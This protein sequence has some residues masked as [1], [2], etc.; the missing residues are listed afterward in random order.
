MAKKICVIGNS[1]LGAVVK[2]HRESAPE[3]DYQFTFFGAPWPQ[4]DNIAVV[5]NWI[6]GATFSY[7]DGSP[8]V[9]TYDAFV[10]YGGIMCAQQIAIKDDEMRDAGFS[11]AVRVATLR[12]QVHHSVCRKIVWMLHASSKKPVF[13]L[14]NNPLLNLPA[15]TSSESFQSAED[16]L[17]SASNPGRYLSFPSDLLGEG[18][19]P[20]KQFFKNSVYIDGAERDDHF[21][22]HD[23]E[24]MNVM[25][26]RLVLNGLIEGLR[27]ALI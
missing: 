16:L 21:D 18:F 7:G 8:E 20:K 22:F 1:H 5:N 15:I 10:V 19:L 17:R 4:F 25:G 3:L 2:A 6:M 26:G 9:T 12:N 11:L 27:S 14:S 24:H 23:N 13:L